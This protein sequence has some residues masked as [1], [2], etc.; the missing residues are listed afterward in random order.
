MTHIIGL[1]G[2]I[3]SGKT[4]ISDHFASLGVPV[5]DT[6]IIARIIVEPEQPAL[7]ELVK[8]FGKSILL[9]SGHLD[10]PQ[11]RKLAFA[12]DV[13]KAT[14]DAITHPAIRQ[15]TLEQIQTA[16][17]PYCIVVV[18]LL[19][20]NSPFLSIMKRVLVVT[21]NRQVK[22]ERVEKRSALRPDEI[23]RIMQ[24]QLND[25]QRSLLANDII[26]N[27]GSIKDA[28]SS[29]EQ[30]HRQYLSLANA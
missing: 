17:Y 27:D 2:G 26:V 14:L 5:I 4:V 3:G 10:R 21:A 15:E 18:P 11:L 29:V 9:E 23:E 1:T 22:I 20:A 25:Q 30:L 8:S 24:T 12:D 16:D 19:A 7:L 13:S 28:Q 6:D